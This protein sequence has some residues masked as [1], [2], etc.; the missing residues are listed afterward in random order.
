MFW[1]DHNLSAD[2]A[3]TPYAVPTA[4]PTASAAGRGSRRRA[5]LHRHR[6]FSAALSPQRPRRPRLIALLQLAPIFTILPATIHLPRR[7]HRAHHLRSY[8]ARLHAALTFATIVSII[9]DVLT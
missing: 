8:R 9:R 4:R 3:V 7:N 6:R 1:G 2:G 5:A